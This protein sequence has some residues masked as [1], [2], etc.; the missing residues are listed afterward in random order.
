MVS[1]FKLHLSLYLPQSNP[2]TLTHFAPNGYS[3]RQIPPGAGHDAKAVAGFPEQ[4]TAVQD[5]IV[6]LRLYRAI[7][8]QA[9]TS[10]ENDAAGGTCVSALA[11]CCRERLGK[12]FFV[13]AVGDAHM[14]GNRGEYYGD[15]VEFD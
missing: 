14:G 2:L 1:W 13:C 10:K 7:S 11:G 12:R 6:A 5:G 9:S 15:P 3:T 4:G 8:Q